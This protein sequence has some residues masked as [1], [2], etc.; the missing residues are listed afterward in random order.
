MSLPAAPLSY[1]C[2]I[3]ER[4][5][6]A[7]QVWRLRL[8]RPDT[9]VEGLADWHFLAGQY[10]F[11]GQ[12]DLARPYSIA[13]APQRDY[14][15]LH[16]R[17]TGHGLS[18]L[19]CTDGTATLQVSAAQGAGLPDHARARPLLLLAGGVGIA[20]VASILDGDADLAARAHLYW[21]AARAED[22]YLDPH[23]R[24]MAAAHGL[25]Y[26]PILEEDAPGHRRGHIGPAIA[27]DLPDLSGRSIY[28]AGPAAMLAATLPQLTALR[29]EKA[30][31]FGDGIT[32]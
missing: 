16:I 8:S 13:S 30:Y 12:A 28:L 32:V 31:I 27:E 14:I 24:E 22:L 11:V 3:L 29:A 5:S 19:L 23:W 26:H 18:H 17:D 7:P 15:D 20:P 21:G 9:G 25:A 4:Q 1:Q 6:L 2:R 10:V